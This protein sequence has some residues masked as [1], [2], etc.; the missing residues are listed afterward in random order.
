MSITYARTWHRKLNILA[1]IPFLC[2][3][4]KLGR[5]SLYSSFAFEYQFLLGFCTAYPG[6]MPYLSLPVV[7]SVRW[8]NRKKVKRV[9]IMANEIFLNS[10]WTER[11]DM[12]M[13][14]LFA[15]VKV[16]GNAIPRP[17]FYTGF[18]SQRALASVGARIPRPKRQTVFRLDALALSVI[19][20]ATWLGGWVA[21]CHTPVLYQN[22]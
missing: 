1:Y 3:I 21:G 9:A 11:I 2:G 14:Q 6:T 20:T 4:I 5:Q 13:L 10:R 12:Q 15:G 18:Q 8:E 17:A 22:R 7:C 19:A 16:G